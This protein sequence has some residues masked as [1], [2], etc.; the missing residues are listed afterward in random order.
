MLELGDAAL[1]NSLLL[2]PWRGALS[3][4]LGS[5]VRRLRDR[6]WAFIA[7]LSIIGVLQQLLAGNEKN[8]EAC[9]FCPNLFGLGLDPKLGNHSN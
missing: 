4:W 9:G 3:C 2:W 8:E 7:L 6:W 5:R 1:L